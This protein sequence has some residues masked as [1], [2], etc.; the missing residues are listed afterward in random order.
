MARR[1]EKQCLSLCFTC[2]LRLRLTPEELDQRYKSREIDKTLEK[3]KHTFKKQVRI[4]NFLIFLL[5]LDKNLIDWEWEYG[6]SSGGER[7]FIF[8]FFFFLNFIRVIYLLLLLFHLY[9]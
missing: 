5:Q 9:I 2:L 3:E 6:I 8:V 4:H 7:D 1:N